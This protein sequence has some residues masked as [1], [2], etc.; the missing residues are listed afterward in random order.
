[1]DTSWIRIEALC[2]QIPERIG[3]EF[4]EIVPS[5]EDDY[6]VKRGFLRVSYG[7]T[8]RCSVILPKTSSTNISVNLSKT[9]M[10][11]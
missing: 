7:V 11:V 3:K 2:V 1:M 8:F 9:W 6:I 5:E 10:K 4:P